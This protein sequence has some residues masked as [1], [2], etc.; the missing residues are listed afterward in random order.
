MKNDWVELT[1]C[2]PVSLLLDLIYHASMNFFVVA[3]DKL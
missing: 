2:F 1:T 3:I